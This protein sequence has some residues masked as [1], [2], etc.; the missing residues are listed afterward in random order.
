[1]K[2]QQTGQEHSH[3][4]LNQSGER[5]A[6][7]AWNR[8]GVLWRRWAWSKVFDTQSI[9]AGLREKEDVAGGRCQQEDSREWVERP[10]GQSLGGRAEMPGR[11]HQTKP[12]DV[13]S[14]EFPASIIALGVL[15]CTC[16]L[17]LLALTTTTAT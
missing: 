4:T 1:M 7:E 10:P 11:I 15:Y 5:E 13:F 14:P 8:W 9:G 17:L 6:N 2:K 16:V 3:L 12:G